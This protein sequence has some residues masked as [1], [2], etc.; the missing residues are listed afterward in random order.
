MTHSLFIKRSIFALYAILVGYLSLRTTAGP[1]IE[2]VDKV[3]H[4]GVYGLFAVLGF[5]AV[6][7]ARAFF[8]ICLAIIAYGG[9]LEVAQFY[10]ADRVMSLYDFTA[11]TFGVLTGAAVAIMVKNPWRQ[12]PGTP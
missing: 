1:G 7:S 6:R 3:M 12:R 2:H 10:A 8:W 4:F 9:L 11:N 5:T